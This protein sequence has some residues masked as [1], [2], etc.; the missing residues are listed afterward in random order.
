M[1]LSADEVN[2]FCDECVAKY[3]RLSADRELEVCE[4]FKKVLEHYCECC[5]T[6]QKDEIIKDG[7]CRQCGEQ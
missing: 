2:P 6:Y 4:K 7:C 1:C 3:K 5:M